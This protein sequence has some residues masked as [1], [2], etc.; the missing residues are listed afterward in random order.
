MKMVK[1]LI[2][3]S[4]A[5][6]LAMGGAQAAD[7]PVKAKAVEYVKIC[8]LYGAGFFYIPGTDTCIKLGGYLRV[9]TTFNGGIY[10]LTDQQIRER[11]A[12]MLAQLLGKHGLKARIVPHEAVSRTRIAALDVAGIAMMCISFINVGGSTAR[13]RYLLRRLRGRQP[14]VRLLLGL[15]PAQDTEVVDGDLRR[16][17]GADFYVTSLR[18]AVRTCLAEAYQAPRPQMRLVTAAQEAGQ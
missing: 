6:L 18:E 1:S 9:D 11:T 4:A 10:D 14:T 7:L 12:R 3:G 2:L 17:L 15:W 13:L 8:S 16:A 5:G